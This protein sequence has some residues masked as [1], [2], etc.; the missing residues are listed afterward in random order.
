MKLRKSTSIAL[1][2]GIPSILAI[3]A[4]LLDYWNTI[5]PENDRFHGERAMLVVDRDYAPIAARIMA[6]AR[7]SIYLG[8]L[9]IGGDGWPPAQTVNQLV[10]ELIG[11]E[12]RGVSVNVKLDRFITKP[13]YVRSNL[14]F[15]SLLSREGVDVSFSPEDQCLH[16]KFLVVDGNLSL[17]WAGN[18]GAG[19]LEEAHDL[20]VLVQSR[21]IAELLI[22]YW[23]SMGSGPPP[24]RDIALP[25]TAEDALGKKKR[26][27]GELQPMS[28]WAW[29][30]NIG[31]T[32]AEDRNYLAAVLALMGAAEAE[33]LV[34]QFELDE[35]S[36][37]GSVHSLVK[38]L[39]DAAARGAKVKVVIDNEGPVEK[40]P[41]AVRRSVTLLSD[42][43]IDMFVD[44][45]ARAMHSKFIVID[46]RHSVIGST[47]WT[48]GA[49]D[50]SR[51]LS[52]ILDS[53]EL[54]EQAASYWREVAGGEQADGKGE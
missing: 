52:L 50:Y 4:L 7:E 37:V 15:Y 6:G 44:G 22:S 20:G 2:I 48:V 18:W 54:A 14:Y 19:S 35:Y 10:W 38:A 46:R 27:W 43:G 11:A 47:N 33:L 36:E 49:L 51:E 34:G 3:G 53:A 29:A 31:C 28:K 16:S 39:G 5:P 13:E 24:Q 32:L 21:R 17:V 12:R 1:Y 30:E 42:T 26:I 23:K 9:R 45:N 8:I 41:E 40:G 25:G